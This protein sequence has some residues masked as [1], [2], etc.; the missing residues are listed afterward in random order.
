[1]PYSI[2]LQD[3]QAPGPVQGIVILVQ[4]QE[5]RMEDLLPRGYNLMNQLDLKCGC[6]C[7][8]TYPESVE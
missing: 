3:T 6:S 7:T 1:M 5:D 8:V 4:V 2:T